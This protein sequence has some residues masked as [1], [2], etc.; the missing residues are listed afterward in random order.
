M[1]AFNFTGDN[2]EPVR[3]PEP[4]TAKGG[5]Y[6]FGKN[7]KSAISALSKE[8]RTEKNKKLAE[9]RKLIGREEGREADD[10]T[11]ANERAVDVALKRAN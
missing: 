5:F 2:F 10:L 6:A 8:E 11:F 7:S 3:K 4:K 1:Q 9:Y